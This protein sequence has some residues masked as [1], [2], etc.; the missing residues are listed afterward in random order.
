MPE[1]GNILIEA[2]AEPLI[3]EIDER[4]QAALGQQR[5]DLHP[6]RF[7]QDAAGRIVAACMQQ[8]SPGLRSRASNM[9][10]TQ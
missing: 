1:A 8:G 5:G 4:Q 9:V 10:S 7:A 3:G 6:L 2:A